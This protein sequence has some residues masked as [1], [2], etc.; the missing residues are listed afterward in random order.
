M[1]DLFGFIFMLLMSALVLILLC[2][3]CNKKR[4]ERIVHVENMGNH[5]DSFLAP[6]EP[7]HYKYV[8]IVVVSV[9]FAACITSF[10]KPMS[11]RSVD[12]NILKIYKTSIIGLQLIQILHQI[13][14]ST[15][16]DLKPISTINSS[17]VAILIIFASPYSIWA[18]YFF[19]LFSL[20][21]LRLKPGMKPVEQFVMA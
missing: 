11:N 13:T 15:N 17:C 12:S 20:Y 1:P 14:T 3:C 19:S 6:V 4:D 21:R 16:V 8:Q 18:V 7:V 9:T 2:Y 5:F 10:F